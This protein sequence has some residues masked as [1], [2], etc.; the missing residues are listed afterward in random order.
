MNENNLHEYQR[1]GVNFIIDHPYCGLFL[2]CGLGKTVTTLTAINH[3]M[4]SELE[5]RNCLIIAPKRVA[6]T[7][8]SEEIEKWEHLK[9]LKLSKIIGPEKKRIEALSQLADIY[10]ISR[11]N[12]TWL[13]SYFGG[14]HLP[15]DMLVIDELSSF[16]SYKALRFKALKVVR[17]SLQRVVGLTGTPAPNG[18]IDLWPQMYLIDRGQRLEKTVSRYRDKYFKPGRSNGAIV[19]NY[20][21]LQESEAKIHEAISDIC[22]SMKANDY[23]KMPERIDNYIKIYLPPEIQAAYNKFEE[24]NILQV[25]NSL[26]EAQEVTALNAAALANK[27][28]QF[29]NGAV[30]DENRNVHEIHDLKIDALRDLIEDSNGQPILCAWAYQ[31]DRDR[32]MKKLKVYNPRELKAE[33]DIKDWND[34]KINLLLAHP[35]SVGHGLNLQ[36]GGHIIVWFGNTWSLE[37]YQQFNARVLRQGQTKESV[38]IHHLVAIDT[39]DKDVIAA[40]ANKD[41]KQNALLDSIKAKISKYLKNR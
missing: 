30:Y 25:I 20:V 33:K 40:I 38:I 28:L 5:I 35:A 15:Y 23:L 41:K 10:I 36:R 19:Y 1:Y 11:D 39:H 9:H 24:E 14:G 34:G 17:P 18:L 16:K 31:H 37:L 32:I 4:Y 21:P 27:L 3:L 2:D 22:V 6:E 8:W 13:C 26:N 12:I 7:V 29:A